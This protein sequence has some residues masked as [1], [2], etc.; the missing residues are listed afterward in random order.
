MALVA[1]LA[2]ALLGTMTLLTPAAPAA[3]MLNV[4]AVTPTQ[5]PLYL[6]LVGRQTSLSGPPPAVTPEPMIGYVCPRPP[7]VRICWPSADYALVTGPEPPCG[8]AMSTRY[9]LTPGRDG[10]NLELLETQRVQ[11]WGATDET[12]GCAPLV[13]VVET[14][15]AP[16]PS[17]LP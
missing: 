4:A 1:L 9:Y 2:V 7:E 6:P 5:Y 17:L 8:R 11:V 10:V 14:R 16:P 13:H 3:D 15:P 12:P